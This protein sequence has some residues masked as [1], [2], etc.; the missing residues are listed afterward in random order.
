MKV[1]V[2]R[3]KTKSKDG[4]EFVNWVLLLPDGS[5]VLVKPLFQ[6]GSDTLVW[7]YVTAEQEKGK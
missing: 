7:A 5:K 3:E 2:S 4:R 1:E 6:G